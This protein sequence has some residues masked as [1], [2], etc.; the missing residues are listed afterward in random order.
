MGNN[1]FKTPTGKQGCHPSE[2][3]PVRQ[4]PDW[5][6]FLQETMGTPPAS[7]GTPWSVRRSTS[8]EHQWRSP[9][10]SPRSEFRKA[11]VARA[12]EE[13]ELGRRRSWAAKQAPEKPLPTPQ[14]A[15]EVKQPFRVVLVGPRWPSPHTPT[16]SVTGCGTFHPLPTAGKGH[17]L[18]WGA[19]LRLR[20]PPKGRKHSW[21]LDDPSLKGDQDSASVST[22]VSSCNHQSGHF[23]SLL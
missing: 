11:E 21:R 5:L 20:Q 4:A 22:T 9:A 17:K 23:T 6:C 10:T 1:Y 3:E 8:P 18:H 14:W 2:R 13:A 7:R 19:S 15:P 12:E 16:S